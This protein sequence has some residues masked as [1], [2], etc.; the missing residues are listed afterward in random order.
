MKE[1]FFSLYWLA[2]F[3]WAGVIFYLSH[4]PAEELPGWQIPYLDKVVHA[5]EFGILAWLCFKSFRAFFPALLFSF[6]YALSDE[7][8]QLFVPGRCPDIYDLFADVS[9]I[10]LALFLLKKI[11]KS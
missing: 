8:H 4:L 7:F 5:A 11:D 10:F 9:G 2:L 3:L 1:K 6:L